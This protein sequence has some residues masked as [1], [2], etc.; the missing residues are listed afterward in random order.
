MHK[1]DRLFYRSLL[2]GLALA[3]LL[4]PITQRQSQRSW[5]AFAKT[6]LVI[7][8]QEPYIAAISRPSVWPWS[9]SQE[10]LLA[11]GT[12]LN[13]L[14]QPSCFS[15]HLQLQDLSFGKA[16]DPSTEEIPAGYRSLVF[17]L[18][19]QYSSQELEAV[20]AGQDCILGVSNR[21]VLYPSALIHEP[22]AI[23]QTH[24]GDLRDPRQR[25]H[26]EDLIAMQ[27]QEVIVAV[28]DTGIDT[29][30]PD[31]A[32]LLWENTLEKNGRAGID[33]DQN[34]Y[35]DD[36]NGFDFASRKS[37][38]S[39]KNG[40]DHGTHVAGLIAAR[41]N[42]QFGIASI[43]GPKIRI[44]PLNVTGKYRGAMTEDIEEAI[45]YA[46]RQGAHI[47]NISLGSPGRAETLAHA[48]SEAVKRG[49]FVVSSAGN[50][51]YSLDENFHVPVSYAVDIDGYMSVGAFDLYSGERCEESN[52]SN[53]QIE[54]FAAGCDSRNPS[55]GL[56]ST[57]AGGEFGYQRG[58]SMAAPILASAAAV[59]YSGRSTSALDPRFAADLEVYFRLYSPK[60]DRLLPWVQEG[61]FFDLP[62][63]SLSR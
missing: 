50:N 2:L 47:I 29:E 40:Y 18:D 9:R 26:F 24:L 14:L 28:I 57:R 63:L 3:F 38:P 34:G 56:L 46:I 32:G 15:P 8:A 42:N 21:R 16:A 20:I 48:I 62:A 5:S 37:D 51:N 60:S 1:I 33:D 54:I 19:R 6:K 44:L 30:H 4:Y 53:S 17:F 35:I 12:P 25:Q 39:H 55:Q 31:F 11:E 22:L 58:T 13:V 36:V 49:I 27:E 45:Y 23:K 41:S 10:F 59:F 61:R 43:T 52:H 7:D